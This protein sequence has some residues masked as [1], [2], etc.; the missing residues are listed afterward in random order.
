MNASLPFSEL[1]N[2]VQL[3]IS[4]NVPNSDLEYPYTLFNRARV[5]ITNHKFDKGPN[6]TRKKRK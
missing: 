6:M 1:E 5:G 4:Q 3:I 2:C